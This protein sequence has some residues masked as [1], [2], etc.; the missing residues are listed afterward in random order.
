MTNTAPK[1]PVSLAVNPKLSSWVKFESDGQVTVSPGKVEIGQGIITALAQIAADEL[2]VDLS[3][4]RMVRATTAGS[5][6]EGVTSGSLSIQQ[7]GRALRQACAE[8]RHIFIAAA[9]DRLGVEANAL[10][11][12]DGTIL[13]PGNVRTSYWELADEVSLDRDASMGAAPKPIARRA[14][15][16][17]SVERLDIPDKVFVHP[18]FIHDIALPGML[19]GRVLR[20]EEARAKLLDLREDAARKIPGLTAIVRDGNFAG[21]VCETEHGAEAALAALRK[22][23]KWST[24]EALPDENDLAAFLMAQPVESTVIDTRAA[25]VPSQTAHTISRQYTRP[26]IAHA[27]IAPSC[28]MA[29]WSGDHVHVWTHSQGVY[30]LRADLALVLKVPAENITVE[31]LEGAGCYGHNP[32][33]DVALDAVLLAKAASG[34]PVRVQ[35]SRADEMTHAPFG[36]AMTIEIEADL[37]ASNEIV[38]WRHSIWSNGHA[39]RPGRAAKPALLAGFELQDP[40]PRV[41]SANPPQANGGGGDRNAI[42][43]YDFP[44]WTIESHRLLTMPI[45]TSALRTLG[46]QGN[47]FAI[48]SIVDEIAQLRGEDPVAFRLRHLSDER[49]KDVIR[50]AARRANWKPKA[51]A[52]TGYGVGFSRYKNMGAYCAAVAEIEGDEDIR[53]RKLWLAVDVGEAINPDG[54]INQVEGGAIQATSW[55]LKER[56]RFDGSRITSN[57]WTDYPILRFSEVPQ[58]EVEV[59]QRSDIDPVGAGE[60]AHGP[61]TAA[62]A[63]AVFDC[64]SIRVRNL[65]ITRERLIAAMEASS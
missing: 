14:L 61:V 45:R 58:V 12:G 60:A 5:P 29:Q 34:R 8:I 37:D 24:G 52:G 38:G 28:A 41:I 13:G 48:E 7:S 17:R 42:P 33:D 49:A 11:I 39:A 53:V 16:G 27:S 6:N 21:L 20:P 44:A 19:H 63:N 18:R 23:A 54:V 26:Y 30:L 56:V 62:I 47:V 36:A 35:W 64:L 15:A 1:L 9:A 31:H 55:V 32:A 43:L 22:G 4:V 46:A 57:S 65:P 10:D 2:D 59:I 50:A 40:F 51:K 25:A 3:R